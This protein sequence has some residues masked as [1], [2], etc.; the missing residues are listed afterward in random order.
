MNL[1]AEGY[2]NA[3]TGISFIDSTTLKVCKNQRIHNHKIF[4]GIAERGKS[5]MGWFYG[6]KLH[7]V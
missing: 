7:L 6:F 4:K 5:S 1:S 3:T 2:R